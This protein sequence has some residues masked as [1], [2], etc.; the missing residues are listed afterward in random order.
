MSNLFSEEVQMSQLIQMRRRIKAIETIK[1]ITS[2]MRLISR[3]F[4]M[5]MNKEQ[6]A[7][8]TYRDTLCSLFA[9]LHTIAPDWKPTKFFPSQTLVHKELLIIIGGQKGLCGNFNTN[10]F[11]WIDTHKKELSSP[12]KRIIVL[13]KRVQE[14]LTKR[15]ITT[16][17][18]YEE[19]KPKDM[20]TFTDNLLKDIFDPNEHYTKISILSNHPKTFFI[21]EQRYQQLI[22]FIG[23]ADNTNKHL[24]DDYHWHHTPDMVLNMLAEDFI[25]VSIRTALFE[26]LLAEQ[27]ARFLSM[28]NATRNANKFLET[29]Q[30]Q[31]NKARQAK[32][33]KE[34]T[35]LAGAFES[36]SFT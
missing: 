35:E 2:A 26:S 13:G 27:A 25:K 1:K 6:Q 34:L 23:C 14:H 7:L 28:D 5:R 3:S 17:K 18:T 15:T 19:L 20:D 21:H 10:L 16:K 33:T 36:D 22:P 31:Y 9:Q 32:I 30:L 29:M 12:D 11:Y 24:A 4:H 8:G